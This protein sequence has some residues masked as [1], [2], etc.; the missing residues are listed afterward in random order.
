MI[1]KCPGCKTNFNV[2]PSHYKKGVRYCSIGCRKNDKKK[3]YICAVCKKSFIDYKSA[4]RK[5]C[6]K[7][8]ASKLH[9]YKRKCQ[10][11]FKEFYAHRASY[12]YCSKKCANKSRTKLITKIC[13]YCHKKFTIRKKYR[14]QKYCSHICYQKT[15]HKY[16]RPNRDQLI[17]LL[18]YSSI[19]KIAKTLDISPSLIQYWMQIYKLKSPRIKQKDTT[20]NIAIKR[21]LDRG[22]RETKPSGYIGENYGV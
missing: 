19:R 18:K 3:T 5:T 10:Y 11:C 8:C 15:I 12:K 13:E 16:R 17:H 1:I 2:A 22:G 4:N 9:Q 7:N 20:K 21:V 6:S 14:K